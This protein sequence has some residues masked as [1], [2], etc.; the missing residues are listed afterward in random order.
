MFSGSFSRLLTAQCVL[1][2]PGVQG[3]RNVG[4]RYHISQPLAVMF[5]LICPVFAL[6]CPVFGLIC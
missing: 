4:T 2:M 1:N 5:A 3:K 6:I